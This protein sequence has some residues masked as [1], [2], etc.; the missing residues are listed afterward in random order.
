MTRKSSSDR[1]A[2]RQDNHEFGDETSLAEFRSR[3]RE[4]FPEAMA[5]I[6]L[7]GILDER[8]KNSKAMRGDLLRELPEVQS[9]NVGR[10]ARVVQIAASREKVSMLAFETLDP[11]SMVG[12]R[13]NSVPLKARSQIA[14][15]IIHTPFHFTALVITSDQLKWLLMKVQALCT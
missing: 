10:L 13:L 7:S 1:A 4:M 2:G 8:V 5:F 3:W 15:Q 14:V 6:S 9:L 11:M 12:T